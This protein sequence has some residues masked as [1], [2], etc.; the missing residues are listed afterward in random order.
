MKVFISQ[1]MN[2]RSEEEIL[3]EREKVVKILEIIKDTLKRR[4][5]SE[6]DSIEI[7]DTYFTDDE[8]EGVKQSGIYW[9]GKSMELLSQADICIFI[10]KHY[11]KF[12]GC[13]LEYLVC[14]KYFIP[15]YELEF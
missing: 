1:A 15:I 9:L 3:N 12:R 10:N 8:P 4:S 14:E 5:R 13:Y 11:E 7:L 2:G 6:D